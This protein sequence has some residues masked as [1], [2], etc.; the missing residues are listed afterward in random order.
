MID[1]FHIILYNSI[2]YIMKFVLEYKIVSILLTIANIKWMFL[3]KIMRNMS[4]DAKER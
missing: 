3:L 2:F 4:K 1:I